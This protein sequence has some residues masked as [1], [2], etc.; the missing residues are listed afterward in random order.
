[1][2]I[3]FIPI[4]RYELPANLPIVLEPYRVAVAL[5]IMLWLAALLIDSRES[6]KASGF[7]GPIAAVVLAAV[8]SLAANPHRVSSLSSNVTK[9]LMFLASF[10]LVFFLVE[11]IARRANVIDVLLKTMVSC[12]A[13]VALSSIY[14]FR[15]GYNVFDH[16]S[17][18]P[19]LR[20]VSLPTQFG[21]VTGYS[22]GGH[23][24]AY[25]SAQ[26]PG[27]LGAALTILLP[28]AIYLARRTRQHRW[29]L[30]GAVCLLGTFT[31]S[32]RASIVMLVA[33]AA[34][35]LWL[36]P[37]ETRRLWPALIP[38]MLAIHIAAPGTLGGLKDAF[39][40]K[41]GLLAQE[42]NNVGAG[43]LATLGPT[44]HTEVYPNAV[45][46]EG[47]GT[48]IVARTRTP[49]QTRRFS[50]INGSE[51]WPRPV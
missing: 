24:R 13:I 43:R 49:S 37:S 6:I 2:V 20:L 21:D 50:T 16:L 26:H 3:F 36:R 25:A 33:I 18:L 7:G 1:M 5:V 31:T 46:G 8:C 14:E 41:G 32:S 39:F 48:R 19:G 34:T 42:A 4:R 12:G 11:S 38:L 27:A 29:W 15:T 22:R 17:G 9:S 23:V 47:F 51:P 28:S 40:P 30:A 10:V 35:Y 45:F 44:L